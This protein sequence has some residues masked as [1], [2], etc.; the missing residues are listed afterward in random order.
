M[1]DRCLYNNNEGTRQKVNSMF[2]S[3]LLPPRSP[4]W[5]TKFLNL[6]PTSQHTISYT[7]EKEDE[8]STYLLITLSIPSHPISNTAILGPNEN[9]TK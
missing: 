3:H 6:S 2:R 9:L 4:Q 1:A 5:L 8:E 7:S